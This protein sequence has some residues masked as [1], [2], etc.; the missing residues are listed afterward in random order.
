[1]EKTAEPGGR[2]TAPRRSARR[3]ADK[4]VDKIIEVEA[5]NA[6]ENG[7]CIFEPWKE[8]QERHWPARVCCDFSL[9]SYVDRQWQGDR[10]D[11][12]D[13]HAQPDS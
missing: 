9:D 1:M 13:L 7:K 11:D 8:R 4:D 5:I 2:R 6:T 3:T 10:H 12:T